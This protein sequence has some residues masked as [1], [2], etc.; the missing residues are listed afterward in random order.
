MLAC[1]LPAAA[2]FPAI[3]T[4]S[5]VYGLQHVGCV[6]QRRSDPSRWTQVDPGVARWSQV[7]PGVV[8]H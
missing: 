8:A 3:F 4:S 2:Q 6:V 1:L 7:D 5:P